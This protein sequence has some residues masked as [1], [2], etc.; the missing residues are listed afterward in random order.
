MINYLENQNGSLSLDSMSI[1][2]SESNRHYRQA[3]KEVE[4]GEATIEAWEGSQRQ[5]DYLAGQADNLSRAA[6]LQQKLDGILIN[7]V[8]CSAT[9]E[10][11]H[12]LSDIEGFVL[13]GQEVNFHF[14]NGNK[15]V[16]T[17]ENWASFRSAW[18]AFRFSFFPI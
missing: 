5:A 6:V 13:G 18:V 1:P 12:G 7:G 10:D 14:E 3:L 4:D 17:A 11:Q 9:A 2:A 16:L 15:L 8:M